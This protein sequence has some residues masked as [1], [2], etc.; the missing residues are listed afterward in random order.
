MGRISIVMIL[1]AMMIATSC[2]V[3]SLQPLYTPETI[4][5]EPEILGTWIDS[6]D[7]VNYTFSAGE[8]NSYRLDCVDSQD[9][10]SAFKCYIVELRG[11]KF[12]DMYPISMEESCPGY[13]PWHLMPVHSFYWIKQLTPALTVST[14]DLGWLRKYTQAHPGEIGVSSY[15]MDDD[16]EPIFTATTEQLQKFLRDNVETPGAFEAEVIL[17]PTKL[18]APTT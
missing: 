11:Q 14:L 12:I 5:A 16:E 4:V 7:E 6:G 3:P 1:I 18:P 13:A 17:T 10:K 9:V 2:I 15:P 8:E